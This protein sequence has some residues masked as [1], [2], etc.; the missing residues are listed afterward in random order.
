MVSPIFDFCAGSSWRKQIS[1]HWKIVERFG[2]VHVNDTCATHVHISP[3][4]GTPWTLDQVKRVAQAILYFEDAFEAVLP[5][6]YRGHCGKKSNRVDNV[7]LRELK[8]VECFG[9]IQACDNISDLILLM[10]PLDPLRRRYSGLHGEQ[11]DREYGWNFENL[12]PDEIGTIG[13][14]RLTASP[15][16]LLTHHRIS[17]RSWCPNCCALHR[18]G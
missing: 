14:S 2:T 12:E 15:N 18:M 5:P 7:T 9:P 6:N 11:T 3:Q 1:H 4:K 8:P 10:Q 16:P 17:S 13:V